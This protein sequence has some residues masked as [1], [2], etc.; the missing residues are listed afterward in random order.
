MSL[1]S[2]VRE[3]VDLH[4]TGDGGSSNQHTNQI[5]PVENFQKH[6]VMRIFSNHLNRQRYEGALTF[7]LCAF[8]LPALYST[9]SKL[10][11]ANIDSSQVVTTDVYTYLG[12]IIEVINEGLP[13]ASWLIIGDKSSRSLASRL[14]LA[15]TL[16]TIQIILGTLLSFVFLA[17]SPTLAGLFVPA[18]VREASL[19]YVRIS[20]F[21]ALS[22]AIEY[23]VS[24]ATRALDRPDVPLIISSTKFLVNIFLDLILISKIHIK[25]V[26]PTVNMQA[27]IR[28]SCDMG[29]SFA[30]LAYFLYRNQFIRRRAEE[31]GIKPSLSALKVLVRPGAFMFTES[32]VRNALYLWLVHGIITMSADYATA[33][34]IFNTIRWGLVMVPVQALEASSLA[35]VGHRW[36]SWRAN[37]GIE[38]LRPVM[39]KP[40]MKRIVEPAMKSL[41]LALIVEVPL[42]IFFSIW[43][44]E[45]FALFLSDSEPVAII[46]AKMWKTI[47]WCYIFYAVST[48]LATIPLA[49]VPRWYLY[50]SL[51]SNIFWVL[52]WA[53]TVTQ[54]GMTADTAWRY[55]S[56]VFGGSLVVSFWI[57]LVVDALW[58][59]K[60]LKGKLVLPFF[61]DV[62]M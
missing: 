16:I 56:V 47:D 38:E 7:N 18:A 51:V 61:S 34:G 8:V 29:A 35:F 5:P 48:Q 13:R 24:I 14:Q 46:T 60:L 28:L 37:K 11:V 15:Y 4:I 41:I 19:K 27:V 23:S 10:W 22:S 45:S 49:T 58:A 53:I 12:V 32:A 42:C 25:Q 30:G 9:L 50:Q 31:S 55:H 6:S 21:L 52:P 39:T 40:E 57:I 59:W 17:A 36:G 1:Q 2:K 20:S 54:I 62:D 3:E 43:G 26:T 44:A 33:W